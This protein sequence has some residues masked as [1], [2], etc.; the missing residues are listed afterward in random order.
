MM[1]TLALQYCN[2]H[3][4]NAN[5]VSDRYIATLSNVQ[6]D[7]VPGRTRQEDGRNKPRS[8]HILVVK[9]AYLSHVWNAAIG[10]RRE[11]EHS[12]TRSTSKAQADSISFEP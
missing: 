11:I 3:V 7:T 8:F 4:S 12:S 6:E 1:V 5:N 10:R 9:L 2:A